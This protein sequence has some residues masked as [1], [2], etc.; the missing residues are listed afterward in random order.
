VGALQ[1]LHKTSQIELPAFEFR[2]VPCPAL[3]CFIEENAGGNANVEALCVAPHRHAHRSTTMRGKILT[4]AISLAAHHDRE[5]LLQNREIAR[6]E[7][8][9]GV[10]GDPLD[11]LGR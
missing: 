4:D 9:V 3:R 1:A 10:G 7:L 11:V 5:R 8:A 2:K 6:L